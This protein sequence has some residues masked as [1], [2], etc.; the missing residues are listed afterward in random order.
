[1]DKLVK[2][3]EKD[4]DMVVQSEIFSVMAPSLNLNVKKLRPSLARRQNIPPVLPFL[5]E[6]E[7]L[8]Q[9]GLVCGLERI[10][11]ENGLLSVYSK[12]HERIKDSKTLEV[13]FE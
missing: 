11:K 3:I 8:N 1:M 5:N 2:V 9:E 4:E 7:D 13:E 12:F 10:V 6:K